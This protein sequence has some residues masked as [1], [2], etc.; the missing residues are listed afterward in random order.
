MAARATEFIIPFDRQA[1]VK[2]IKLYR[3]KIG[4]LMYLVTQTRPDIV[5]GISIL[6]WFLLNPSLQYIKAADQIL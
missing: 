2:V 3:S 1:T 6:L 5:Y 4:S